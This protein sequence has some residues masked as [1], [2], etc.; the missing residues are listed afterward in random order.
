M[1]LK[2]IRRNIDILDS[3]ILKAIN[4]R[5]EQALLA[6]KY[7][8]QVED[9]ERENELLG[10]I[11]KNLGRLI[12]PDYCEKLYL[13][14]LDKSKFLQRQNFKLIGF[15]G[16]HGA[17]SEAASKHWDSSHVPVPCRDFA[18]V[19]DGVSSGKF[20]YGMVPVENTLG[21]VVGQVDDLLINT[22][23]NVVG[24]ID[25]PVHHCL[26]T[27]PGTDYRDIRVVY[28]HA[29]ALAQCRSFLS[30]NKLELSP[31]YDTAGAARWLI[32]EQQS[33]SAAIASKLAAELY[34][35]E[36]IKE[37]IED[38]AT[39]S[40]R[41]FI[42]S[43]EENKN[44]GAKGSII[45]ST[46]HKAGALFKVLE[47][48]AKAE[49]N[50]TRIESVPSTP[51]DFAFFIDFVAEDR[52]DEAREILEKISKMTTDFK[53]LGFYNERRVVE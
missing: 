35:L 29:Q 52:E 9:Q 22:D 13:D 44:G 47:Y 39:N 16:D 21:G 28:S 45:F 26:L 1:G 4:D 6:S 5:M 15:Q 49:M 37:N 50:L 2:E 42:V 14:I 48:F 27:L 23:L 31:Y 41:F 12:D 40:T 32:E 34:N 53:I 19:F 24:A 3:K 11:R 7:K 36:V 10:R 17:Y 38:V 43:K 51:G 18:D 20:D 25:F 46:E 8:T 33:G 30:R